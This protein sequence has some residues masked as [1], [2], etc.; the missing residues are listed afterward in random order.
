MNVI[1]VVCT[2]QQGAVTELDQRTVGPVVRVVDVQFEAKH[3][4]VGS[5]L[6]LQAGRTVKCVGMVLQHC[7]LLVGHNLRYATHGN[8][9]Q[10]LAQAVVVQPFLNGVFLDIG[11]HFRR[12]ST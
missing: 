9:F 8:Q 3:V 12:D 7:Q 4:F 11:P 2:G 6:P 1:V 5:G 10:G